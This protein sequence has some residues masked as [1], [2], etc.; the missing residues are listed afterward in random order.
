MKNPNDKR[1][2][3][4]RKLIIETFKSM[5]IEMEYS[6]ITIKNLAERAN[7]NRKTFYA[8]FE[9]IEDVLNELSE[10]IA[11]VLYKNMEKVGMFDSPNIEKFVMAMTAT[12]EENFDLYKKIMVA[13]S[14]RFF[15]R[16]IKNLFKN[17]V[18]TNNVTVA[19]NC[20]NDE[21]DLCSEF[22]AS[23]FAKIYK[24][25]MENPR[26]ITPK[27]IAEIAGKMT[28]YGLSSFFNDSNI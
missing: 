22:I 21:L 2:I 5:I 11:D 8:H 15:I 1:V 12:A 3:K 27:R 17:S 19:L 28:F 26:D 18:F 6:D 16:N 14:Y 10:E 9:C 23:G 24:E 25:W 13:N 20:T 7:I 4:T